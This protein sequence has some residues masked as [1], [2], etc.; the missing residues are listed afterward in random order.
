M[1][2]NEV[3]TQMSTINTSKDTTLTTLIKK[4]AER[5]ARKHFIKIICGK[6]HSIFK[7]ECNLVEMAQS[8]L[9]EMILVSYHNASINTVK[10]LVKNM[11]RS[12][13]I[14]KINS[15]DD[16]KSIKDDAINSFMEEDL[17]S[18]FEFSNQSRGD[19]SWTSQS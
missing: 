3:N 15:Y 6:N 13:A 8:R 18:V 2:F 12:F 10:P 4:Y 5:V 11:I 16:D 17:E 9:Q 19:N 7:T 14:K 1:Y